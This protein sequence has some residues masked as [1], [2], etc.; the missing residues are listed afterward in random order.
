MPLAR[1]PR[2]LGTALTVAVLSLALGACTATRGRRAA[3]PES[4]FLRDYSKL[5]PR[6]GYPAS[7]IYIRPG[8]D[9]ARYGS[10]QIDSVTLW[11]NEETGKLSEQDRQ[12]LTDTLYTALHDELG[13]FFEIV[14]EPGPSTIRIRVALTQARGANVPLRT[15]TTVV[16]Q[17]R[18]LSAAVGLSADVA[19]TVGT[20]TVEAEAIDSVTGE[21]LAAAVDERSGNKAL[22][23][24]RTF[25]K[26]GD[27]EAACRYWARR[28]AFQAAKHGV[29]RKPGAGMPDPEGG[30]T[31]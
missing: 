23:T 11:V 22:F 16:P 20:A 9:W 3:P 1:T 29:R 19:F 31:F 18:L 26:W 14:R 25:T 10:I 30:R 27:V 28:V 7:L 13:R 15:L 17:M 8:V 6:E 4:G 5:E 2:R 24:T 21:R 12:M